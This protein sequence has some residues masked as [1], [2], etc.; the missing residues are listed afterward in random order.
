MPRPL[1]AWLALSVVLSGCVTES[2]LV[3][4]SSEERPGPSAGA[5]TG[6]LAFQFVATGEDNEVFVSG[7]GASDAL[8][9]ALFGDGLRVQIIVAPQETSPIE[10]AEDPRVSV[11]IISAEEG[12]HGGRASVSIL[13]PLWG[14]TFTVVVAAASYEG[15]GSAEFGAVG[16]QLEIRSSLVEGSARFYGP[17]AW[18]GTRQAVDAIPVGA[19]FVDLAL[20]RHVEW[21][22]TE[23]TLAVFSTGGGNV[24]A[25]RWVLSNGAQTWNTD[26]VTGP[27]GPIYAGPEDDGKHSPRAFLLAGEAGNWSLRTEHRASIGSAFESLVVADLPPE[28]WNG[29]ALR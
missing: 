4:E 15:D 29:T 19:A 8:A 14:H 2:T 3:S 24:R 17:A 25:D 18:T 7:T 16:D 5:F 20:E 9:L 10:V 28:L 13:E 21:E 11:D 6:S 12:G 27:L 26:R 1:L 23:G 22:T